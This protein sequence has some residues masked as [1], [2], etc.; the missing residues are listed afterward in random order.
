MVK[1]IVFCFFRGFSHQKKLWAK[2]IND[3]ELMG[4][5]HLLEDKEYYSL[6][7]IF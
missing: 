1:D 2:E 7:N 3:L 4:Q 5:H 6:E